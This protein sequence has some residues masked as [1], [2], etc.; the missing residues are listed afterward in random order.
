MKSLTYKSFCQAVVV[1]ALN[2][3]SW[4][5]EAGGPLCVQG[6]PVLQREFPDNQG[7]TE[8]PYLKNPK[9]TNKQTNKRQHRSE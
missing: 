1:N 9:Q 7:Y 6:Q 8:K 4:E 3:S 5:T 2:P